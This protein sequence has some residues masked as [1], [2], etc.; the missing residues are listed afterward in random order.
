MPAVAR[1]GDESRPTAR[2]APRSQREEPRRAVASRAHARPKP[3]RKKRKRLGLGGFGGGLSV[4]M[5]RLCALSPA[6]L[7][8]SSRY[9]LSVDAG[10]VEGYRGVAYAPHGGA[11]KA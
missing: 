8:G 11:R 5:G 4:V 7:W 10:E 9:F 1:S 3:A 6:Y 2:P